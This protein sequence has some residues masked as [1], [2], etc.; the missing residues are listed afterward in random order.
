M[1]CRISSQEVFGMLLSFQEVSTGG[2]IPGR[3][4][5]SWRDK[6]ALAVVATWFTSRWKFLIRCGTGLDN[7]R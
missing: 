7:L 5:V 4:V 1:G 6:N 2:E 3:E